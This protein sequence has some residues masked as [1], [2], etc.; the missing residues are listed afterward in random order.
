MKKTHT[1]RAVCLKASDLRANK[2]VWG[3]TMTNTVLFLK[4]SHLLHNTSERIDVSLRGATNYPLREKQL[5]ADSC[6]CGGSAPSE[7]AA[8][9]HPQVFRGL[10]RLYYGWLLHFGNMPPWFPRSRCDT[11]GGNGFYY[12]MYV[13]TLGIVESKKDW[14][15]F[16]R[17]AQCPPV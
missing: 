14:S 1:T 12:N 16:Q 6:V 10:A 13:F 11:S 3:K 4:C 2:F 15:D 17:K 7:A 9:F 5:A 8:P